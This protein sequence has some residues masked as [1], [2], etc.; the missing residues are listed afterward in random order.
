MDV[1]TI[2]E[3]QNAML[4]PEECLHSMRELRFEPETLTRTKYFAECRAELHGEAI[5]VYAPIITVSLSMAQQANMVLPAKSK[6][7]SRV[8]IVENEMLCFGLESHVCCLLVE[9]LPKGTMLSEAIYTHRRDHLLQGLEELRAELNRCDISTN[10]LNTNSIIV[11]REHH[12][13]IIRP[14]YTTRGAGGDDAMLDSLKE[15]IMRHSLADS[16]GDTSLLNEQLAPY[17]TCDDGNRTL[18]P[19][20][21][22]MRRFTTA[23]GTG[24]E[25][26]YGNAVIEAKFLTATDFME[27]RAIVESHDHKWGI[28]DR[29]GKFIIDMLYDTLDFD[30]DYGTS[31]V[32]LNGHSATFDYLGTQLTPWE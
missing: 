2:M 18:Y 4:H 1:C 13:H 30:M 15:L 28:I 17:S 26:E 5:M 32:T 11:D 19:A 7:I 10:H 25:D 12:W 3:F 27:D 9:P 24:F 14:Y 23:L 22:G 8:R 6:H 21:E 16:L 31:K 20:S 29:S